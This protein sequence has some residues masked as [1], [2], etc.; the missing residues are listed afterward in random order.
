MV[1]LVSFLA[2]LITRSPIR[3]ADHGGR[4]MQSGLHPNWIGYSSVELATR[5]E[6]TVLLYRGV[7]WHFDDADGA[8]RT[9]RGRG[10]H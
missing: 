1:I 8:S 6:K 10:G 5:L 4:M 7:D 2:G 9:G 3:P